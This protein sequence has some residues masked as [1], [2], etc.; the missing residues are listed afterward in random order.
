MARPLRLPEEAV[1]LSE[2][3]VAIRAPR[4]D[5]GRRR[6]WAPLVTVGLGLVL[7][8][9]IHLRWPGAGRAA[10]TALTLAAQSLRGL[11][12]KQTLGFVA[13]EFLVPK[14]WLQRW[15]QGFLT[16][17]TNASLPSSLL[18]NLGNGYLGAQLGGTCMYVNGLFNGVRAESHRACLPA[19]FSLHLL[20]TPSKLAMPPVGIALDFEHGTVEQAFHWHG[21][22]V[23][24][25]TYMHRDLY[26]IAVTEVEINNTLNAK[27]LM[28]HFA[29]N[30]SYSDSEDIAWTETTVNSSILCLKGHTKLK[31]SPRASPGVVALC[32]GRLTEALALPVPA[33]ATARHLLLTA[34][35]TGP[36]VLP[37]GFDDMSQAVQH[38]YAWARSLGAEALLDWHLKA[39][40]RL[41]R[42]GVEVEGN[43]PLARD[44]R[45]SWWNLLL[46]YREGQ[47]LS[48]SPGGLAND[49]YHGHSFWDVEQFMW[50]NL[51]M[52]Y[53]SLA[54]ASLQYRADR[55]VV[56]AQ[57]AA[58]HSEMG[59]RF[60]WE[61]AVTGEEVCPW[62]DGTH[63]IHINGDVSM[64][65]WQQWQSSGDLNW[66]REVAWPV[67]QG[68]ARFYASRVQR[69]TN[70]DV[71]MRGI[72]DVDEQFHGVTDS[73]YTNAVAKLA[74]SHAAQAAHLLGEDSEDWSDLAERLAIPFDS[75][76]QRHLI[77]RGAPGG[78]GLG[79]VMM[80]YPLA[81]PL[82]WAHWS[83][84][85]RRHDVSFFEDHNWPHGNAM[86]WW[87]F[88]VA[89]LQVGN[90][91]RADVDFGR[92][93]ARNVFGPFHTWTEAP[94]GGGCPNFVTGAGGYLQALWAGY[95]G[96]RLTD[97]SLLLQ[98]PRLPP[99]ATALHLRGLAYRGSLL[100]VRITADQVQLSLGE[101][102]PRG[103]PALLAQHRPKV[104]GRALGPAVEL[105]VGQAAI[106]PR[107]GLL[108]IFCRTV[109]EGAGSQSR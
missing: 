71:E 91:T 22:S 17:S 45:S 57:N 51:L 66:L 3:P 55:G 105:A 5:T 53:P 14:E 1:L 11:S 23:I 103:A 76:A 20:E 52:F 75:E 58:G 79:V 59:Y 102:P 70:G 24:I 88:V 10:A 81:M 94:G 85:V 99:N 65:F 89:W 92:V 2:L 68:V 106:F 39:M 40:Q 56:A 78:N 29:D 42:S 13:D 82:K 96:V 63:E 30:F 109:G 87:A 25:R 77:Y 67:L 95:G 47:N 54:L 4:E 37:V 50:P 8:V 86:Y 108:R 18:P 60:P 104:L 80:Q 61:S 36:E 84:E 7:V 19:P 41:W 48:S 31:E 34:V 107:K 28:L 21:A 69:H 9:E 38:E 93:T 98:Q 27:P 64:A 83:P 15:N 32:R 73:T 6:L 33:K 62:K 72:T 101:Q 49:C 43:L 44:L 97:E 26:H 16:Y 90:R 46:S 35:W 74:W 12:G 100:D